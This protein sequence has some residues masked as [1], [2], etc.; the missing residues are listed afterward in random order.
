MI[1]MHSRNQYLKELRI[2][3]LKIKSKKM[4]KNF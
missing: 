1:N 4:H 2:K 3:Y